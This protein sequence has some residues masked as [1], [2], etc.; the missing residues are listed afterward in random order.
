MK[1]NIVYFFIAVCVLQTACNKTAFLDQ[2]PNSGIII[3]TTLNDMRLLLD[4]TQVFT[5]SPGLGEMA[6]DDYYLL[7]V[8][9]QALPAIE[10]S[11]YVWDADVYSNQQSISDWSVP[12]QQIL[13]CNIVLEQLEK[14]TPAPTELAEWRD[15]KGAALFARA[16]AMGGLVQ[17]FAVAF[18]STTMASALG[19]PI[20]LGTDVKNYSERST[21]QACYDQIFSDLQNAVLLLL[22]TVPPIAKNRPSRPAAYALLAR[23]AL[24]TEQYSKAKLYADSCLQLYSTVIDYNTVS[25]SAVAPFDRSPQE[26]LY[27]SQAISNYTILFTSATTVFVDT[28]L[29]NQYANN[30]LRKSIFFRTISGTNMGF[31]RGYSGNTLSFTGLATNEVY[32]IRAEAQARLGQAAAAMNDLNALLRNRWRT[33]TFIPLTALNAADALN[34]I[35]IE[36]RKELV[37]R[38]LRWQDLKRYNK[39]GQNITL[40]RVLGTDR[41]TLSP[42]SNKYVFAIPQDEISLSNLIQNPR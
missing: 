32:L 22:P 2:K 14:I 39:Q 17:H 18:D 42:R 38:G 12:Y 16:F 1:K 37:W 9:W 13:Y 36:R 35:L 10:R 31:K 8:N 41:Y 33:G 25:T 15:I 23:T 40:T 5:F 6:A 3:P 20:R 29:F 21:V 11:S 7:P 30:D 27:Y 26:S 28:I 19:V 34:K 24:F 4:Y